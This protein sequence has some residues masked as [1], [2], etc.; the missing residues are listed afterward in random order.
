M[1]LSKIHKVPIFFIANTCVSYELDRYKC[2]CSWAVE[3]LCICCFGE[4]KTKYIQ[5]DCVTARIL[6]GRKKQKLKRWED[7]IY[8]DRSFGF[9]V[10]VCMYFMFVC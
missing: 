7:C 1:R 6:S 4:R 10:C 2:V 3:G 9:L 8:S 5:F